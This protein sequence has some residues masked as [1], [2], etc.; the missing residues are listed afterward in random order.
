M[1]H[2]AVLAL[3]DSSPCHLSNLS[4][5]LLAND[6]MAPTTGIELPQ[7]PQRVAQPKMQAPMMVQRETLQDIAHEQS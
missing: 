6:T 3:R 4:H 5:F 7:Q 1:R 2:L